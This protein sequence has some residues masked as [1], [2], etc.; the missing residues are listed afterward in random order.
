MYRSAWE[1]ETYVHYHAVDLANER[2]VCDS[3]GPVAPKTPGLLARLRRRLGIELIAL[4]WA[5]ADDDDVPRLPA[6][7]ALGARS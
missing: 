5:L 4:G 7:P 2:R 3:L 6:T 1:I